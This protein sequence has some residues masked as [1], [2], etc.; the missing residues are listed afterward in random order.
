MLISAFIY[1]VFANIINHS[2][3]FKND[4]KISLLSIGYL[5]LLIIFSTRS[6]TVPDTQSYITSY[7]TPEKGVKFEYLYALM[8]R[9]A[10]SHRLSFNTFLL[11]FEIIL[12]SLW[13]YI[14]KKNFKNPHIV[15]LVFLPF[16]GIYNYGI[17]IR[18]GMGLTLCYY[19]L[20][21]LLNNRNLKGYFMYFGIV[22]VTIF[23][24]QSMAVFYLLPFYALRKYSSKL[25][26]IIVII[27]IFIP[28][29]NIQHLISSALEIFINFF[30]FKKFLS[31]TQVRAKF[32]T[33]GIY[34]LTFI[35]YIIMAFIFIGIRPLI[36]EKKEMYNFFLNIYITGVVLI[37]LTHYI[38]AGNRLAYIFFFFE[39]ALVGLLY[40]HSTI[41]RKVVLLGALC[42][43]ILN[44][45][46]VVSAVPSMLTY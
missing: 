6:L 20:T 43:S 12:F 17:I 29:I 46:N 13:F 42:L 15:F 30:S 9:I 36:T 23:F 14:S 16:M 11:I 27:S 37:A 38:T 2:K 19:A 1:L 34:S 41:P 5:W 22:T 8:C 28:L 39:F 25:A 26:I 21:F 7:Y 45:V 31:Y 4:I 24:Q 44:Y 10:N 18:T 35:K 40:E 3:G 32:D 33:S